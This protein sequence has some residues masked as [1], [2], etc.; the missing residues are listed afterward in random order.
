MLL[1]AK[2]QSLFNVLIFFFVCVSP[3][4]FDH[5]Q[6]N[7]SVTPKHWKDALMEKV[8]DEQESGRKVGYIVKI[9][10]KYRNAGKY[11]EA[12]L[13]L[14]IALDEFPQEEYQEKLKT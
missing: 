6:E 4:V 7:Q 11:K 8:Y 12:Q 14:E 9:A 10:R 13:Y 2:R 3:C 1:K 5:A